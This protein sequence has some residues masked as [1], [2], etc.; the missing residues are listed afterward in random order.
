MTRPKQKPPSTKQTFANPWGEWDYLCK[1]IHY[2]LYVRREKAK[3]RRY[4]RRLQ[5]VLDRLPRNVVAIIREERLALLGELQGHVDD[6][7]AH[8]Q[9][10][11]ELME[12][13]S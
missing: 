3:A 2:S 9:R 11:I 7:I 4:R 1:K 10:E 12:K 5:D 6:A 13:C 8:R